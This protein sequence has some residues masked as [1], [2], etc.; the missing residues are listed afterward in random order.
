MASFWPDLNRSRNYDG[1]V[2]CGP[3]G[4]VQFVVCNEAGSAVRPVAWTA[5][6]TRLAT[7]PTASTA[8]TATAEQG[9]ILDTT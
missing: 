8:G 4:R 5:C 6:G 9:I 3:W 1:G 2:G 7:A